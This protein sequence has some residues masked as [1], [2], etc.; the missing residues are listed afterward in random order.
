MGLTV[1]LKLDTFCGYGRGLLSIRSEQV[2]VTLKSLSM[3][4]FLK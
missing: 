2:V 3:Y 1:E 4:D